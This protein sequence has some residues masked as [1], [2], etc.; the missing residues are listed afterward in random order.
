MRARLSLL[1]TAGAVLLVVPGGASMPSVL[2]QISGGL[3]EF[4]G[5]RGLPVTRLCIAQAPLL[6]QVE[7]RSAKC[8][9]TVVRNDST[10]AVIDYSCGNGGFGHSKIT[11]LTPRSV[12]IETQGIADQAPFGYVV[13]A[14]R[15]GN[16]PGH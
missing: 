2:S 15:V 9:R 16:C 7:H 8:T 14:R 3:W 4:S 13:R 10:S 5:Q 11:M 6:A 12:R 1:T